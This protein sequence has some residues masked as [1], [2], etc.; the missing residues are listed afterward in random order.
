M[1][2]SAP[3]LAPE[4]LTMPWSAPDLSPELTID[5]LRIEL[6]ERVTGPLAPGLLGSGWRYSTCSL[7]LVK[8]ALAVLPSS[9]SS[10]AWRGGRAGR[11]G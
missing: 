10:T 2:W 6:C 4:L 5:R 9:R 11:S 1:P 8:L 7:M 3:D